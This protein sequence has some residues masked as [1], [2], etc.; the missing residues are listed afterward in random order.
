MTLE[1]DANCLVY[2]FGSVMARWYLVV[3]ISLVSMIAIQLGMYDIMC[4]CVVCTAACV[5][6]QLH[7]YQLC[8][9]RLS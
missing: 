4:C 1:D 2:H 6:F 8:V 9:D 3:V 5:L 7:K